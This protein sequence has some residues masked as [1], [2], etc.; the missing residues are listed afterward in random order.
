MACGS[1]SDEKAAPLYL[2]SDRAEATP[3]HEWYTGYFLSVEDYRGLDA[4]DDNLY[5]GLFRATLQPGDSLTLVASTEA[6]PDLDGAAAY[7]EQQAHERQLLTD[8]RPHLEP[9]TPAIE[10]LVLAADQFIVRR[11]L[12]A[13]PEGRSVIAGYPWFSDWGRDTMIGLPGLALAT[14]RHE[15]AAR[16]LRTFAHYLDRGMLPNRFPDEGQAPEYNTVDATLWYF[17]AIR[18]Y[19]EATERRCPASGPLS[20]TAR[21]RGMAPAGHPLPDPRGSGRWAAL[22]WRGGRAAHLDG[23]QG[24]RLGGDPAPWQA[25]RDQRPVVQRPA[26]HGRFLLPAW[27]AV[28]A[29]RGAGRAGS[30]Q[31]L[32][33]LERRGR[34]T[35]TTSSTALAA[36]T[37][38]SA[39]TSSLP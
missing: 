30:R 3:Q 18:A 12:P 35:A 32:P 16:I 37:L 23:R 4:L 6:D 22:Q 24:G 15:L 20:R 14:G 7:A 38:P 5:A 21:D 1:Q 8:A 13:E 39:Q 34:S 28:R 29:L 17:E 36:T 9:M 10:Q 33:F 25:G 31:L 27:R 19:Y 2:L 26:H 11:C